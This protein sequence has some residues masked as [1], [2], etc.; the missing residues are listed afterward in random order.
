MEAIPTF[1]KYLSAFSPNAPADPAKAR[2][3]NH[4]PSHRP[5]PPHPVPHMRASV[6]S[7]P[8]FHRSSLYSTA[9]STSPPLP[10]CVSAF[11]SLKFAQLPRVP[12]RSAPLRTAAVG[13][14]E[15]EP[16]QG[17][18]GV[19]QGQ[20][21]RQKGQGRCR[22]AKEGGEEGGQAKEGAL[23]ALPRITHAACPWAKEEPRPLQAPE[24][25]AVCLTP[26][27]CTVYRTPWAEGGA[28]PRAPHP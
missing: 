14:A 8:F 28:Q 7:C 1:I 9:A 25:R 21:H 10:S 6:A 19:G 24:R 12:H 22:R 2:G 4:L 15:Q 16:C 20:G 23:Y 27:P 5:A 26:L 13:A 11:A 3:S 17:S 18:P